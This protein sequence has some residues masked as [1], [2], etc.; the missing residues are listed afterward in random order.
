MLARAGGSEGLQSIDLASG[1][2]T[3][4][5]PA[6]VFPIVYQAAFS[7]DG[8]WLSFAAKTAPD[9]SQIFVVPY[10]EGVTPERGA[11]I[12]FTDG[13]SWEAGPQWTPR[14]GTLYFPSERD[15]L[16]A[17]GASGWSLR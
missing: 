1:R 5:V 3:L 9:R 17:F 14:G 8:R 10:R 2:A 12:A 4:I 13:R 11:W 6:G 16:A 15:A 7:P